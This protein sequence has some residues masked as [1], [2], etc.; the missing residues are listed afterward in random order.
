MPSNWAYNNL[1]AF[2]LSAWVKLDGLPQPGNGATLVNKGPEA[3]V[4]HFWWWIGYPPDYRLIL[5]LGSDKHQWGHG[6][7][8]TA[9][10]WELGRWYH[11]ATTFT[12]DGQNCKGFFYRDGQPIGE[13]SFTEGFHSGGHDLKLGVY[14][15]LHW[16]NGTL[17][18]VKLWDRV[19]TPEEVQAEYGR[20][21]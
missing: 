19:L 14:G 3:P 17:D 1:T 10:Q 21:G 4:Q 2:S 9:L 12:S 7:A 8:S 20:G 13:A 15:G 16:L 18:E 6:L 11:V 5:E